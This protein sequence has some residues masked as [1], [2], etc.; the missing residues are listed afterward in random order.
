MKTVEEMSIEDL[1]TALRARLQEKQAKAAP[2][3]RPLVMWA[4]TNKV[5]ETDAGPKFEREAWGAGQAPG[6]FRHLGAE[7]ELTFSVNEDGEA[8]V[9]VLRCDGSLWVREKK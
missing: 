5:F 3:P 1:E 7:V 9:A 2:W 4:Q 8:Q 6:L